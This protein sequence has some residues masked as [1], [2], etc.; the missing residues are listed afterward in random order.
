MTDWR[1]DFLTPKFLIA[2]LAVAIFAWAFGQNVEDKTMLGAIIGGFNLALG[3]YLGSTSKQDKSTDNV[4]KA[5]DA[6]AAAQA[7]PVQPVEKI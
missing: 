5:F 4:G 7:A 3:F 1:A 6:I 2:L